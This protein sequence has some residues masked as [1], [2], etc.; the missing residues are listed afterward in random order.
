MTESR[1][2][3]PLPL[4]SLSLLLLLLQVVARE[5][6]MAFDDIRT[7]AVPILRETGEFHG[8][9][10]EILA[11]LSFI[12]NQLREILTGEISVLCHDYIV[13]RCFAAVF[14]KSLRELEALKTG[15][16]ISL[17]PLVEEM[18]DIV[19]SIGEKV[20]ELD[21]TI[22]KIQTKAREICKKKLTK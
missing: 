13:K 21:A 12:E 10:E 18:R 4:I 7:S 14:S 2:F 8:Q 19:S 6:K 9:M 15:L 3:T 20:K 22:K 16:P 17:L 5:K 1:N 11:T